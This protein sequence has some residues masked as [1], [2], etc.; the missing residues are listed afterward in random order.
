MIFAGAALG[1]L[2]PHA[3]CNT[4]DFYRLAEELTSVIGTHWSCLHSIHENRPCLTLYLI[5][6]DGPR[7]HVWVWASCEYAANTLCVSCELVQQTK[8]HIMQIGSKTTSCQTAEAKVQ[9]WEGAHKPQSSTS[10]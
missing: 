10:A 9:I 3:Q 8:V 7:W 2:L 5:H 4:A 1:Q 6:A